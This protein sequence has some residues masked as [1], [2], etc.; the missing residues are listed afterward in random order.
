MKPEPTNPDA[1]S[2]LRG[3]QSKRLP[4][5]EATAETLPLPVLAEFSDQQPQRY[6]IKQDDN[7]RYLTSRETPEIKVRL[8]RDLSV[9][10]AAARKAPEGTIFLDGTAQ[11]EPF[12]DHERQ[13]FNLDHHEGVIRRFTLSACEQAMVLVLRGLDLRERPWTILANQPDLDT[14]LAIWVLL[15]S[16]NLGDEQPEIRRASIPL[17]RVEGLIDSQGLEFLEFSGMGETDLKETL[18]RLDALREVE[19]S[20][21]D[22]GNEDTLLESLMAQLGIVDRMVYPI[23][24][25]DTMPGVEELALEELSP[26]RIVVVCRCDCGIYEAEPVLKRL[27]G[28][29]LGIVVLQ[30]GPGAYTVRQ[31]DS[32]LPANLKE[33][34]RTLNLV[35]PAVKNSR[36]SN[37]WGGS[38]E[39]GG[40][41]RGSGTQLEPGDI[42]AAC[43]LAYRRPSLKQ[44]ATSAGLAFLLS[45]LSMVVGWVIAA[46]SSATPSWPGVMG[47]R[48]L[49]LFG[50]AAVAVTC[51]LLLTLKASRRPGLFGIRLPAG[52]D[53]LW[54][55]PLAVVGALLGGAWMPGVGGSPNL[56]QLAKLVP[57]LLLLPVVAEITFRGVAQGVLMARYRAQRTGGPW[58][59]SWPALLSAVFFALWTVP[60]YLALPATTA[61]PSSSLVVAIFG[62]LLLGLALGICR[63]R[64]ESLVAP[65]TLH[66]LGAGA[67][68][69]A[70]S[71]L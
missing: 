61:S 53:W 21:S 57:L 40:S 64:A 70:R 16:V 44:C 12:L 22:E 71:L 25:F 7:G 27:Y 50:G 19:L 37:C 38:G 26:D 41:P 67:F 35:D 15:N 10:A 45:S 17:I 1:V 69:L 11:D 56:L 34:Y 36:S 32:F 47:Q 5:D 58:F 39:I 68:L 63:E 42:A 14:V 55:S 52:W 4:D 28:K 65:L 31:V 6:V 66:Y 2:F 49:A 54:L 3:S 46:V 29:R 8:Q 13:V 23:D 51:L 20:A 24:F 48:E 43:Q 62:G 33:A 30:K 60:L 59:V 18:A 9:T